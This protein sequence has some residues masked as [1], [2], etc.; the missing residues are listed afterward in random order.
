MWGPTLCKAF[1]E[2][3]DIQYVNASARCGVPRVPCTRPPPGPAP[4]PA[5]PCKPCSS[6]CPRGACPAGPYKQKTIPWV[7]VA[8]QSNAYGVV[9]G[10]S[11][12][13]LPFLGKFDTA[14]GCQRACEKLS[15][16]TQ[17]CWGGAQAGFERTCYGRCDDIW[18][19]H[20]VT[21]TGGVPIVSGRRVAAKL[22]DVVGGKPNI[23]LAV[24]DDLGYGD[25]GYQVSR[26]SAAVARGSSY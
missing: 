25:V 2:L 3:R 20:A 16:C 11:I 9:A 22:D 4:A 17:F 6:T 8:N 12:A 21:A 26:V 5:C 19:L 18:E 13:G 10:K 1:D 23:L 7:T 14:M 15:N 24:V